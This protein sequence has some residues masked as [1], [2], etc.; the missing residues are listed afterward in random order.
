MAHT[1]VSI[2]EYCNSDA[3]FLTEFRRLLH[4]LR[5]P[6]DREELKSILITSALLAEGKSTV[7]AVLGVVAAQKGIRTILVDCDLRR[8][9]LHTLLNVPKQMGMSDILAAGQTAKTVTKKTSLDKLDLVTAGLT[10]FPVGDILDI[11]SIGDFLSSLKLYYDLVLV[12]S[13]PVIPVSDPMLLASAVDGV[14]MVVKAG[15]TPREVVLRALDI[16][17]SN[18]DKLLG[19]VL[20]NLTGSL[21]AYYDSSH[22][23]YEYSIDRADGGKTAR[24]SGGGS[25][26]KRSAEKTTTSIDRPDADKSPRR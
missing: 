13:P 4:R 3:P 9:N 1:P 19:T 16:L 26:K 24:Q 5:Q 7:C 25:R 2:V 14:L 23:S 20:N 17:R 10:R 15:A 12:D 6:R 18:G 21:P 22:Y 8:P 11:G